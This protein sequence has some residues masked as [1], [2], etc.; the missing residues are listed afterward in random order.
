MIHSPIVKALI[1]SLKHDRFCNLDRWP[2]FTPPQKQKY[3]ACKN[4][5]QKPTP[6]FGIVPISSE[7]KCRWAKAM[8]ILDRGLANE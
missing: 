1:D 5:R 4:K 6:P 8:G 7:R 2:K 3:I